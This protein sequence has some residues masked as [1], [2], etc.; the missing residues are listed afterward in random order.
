[1]HLSF[2]CFKWAKLMLSIEQSI[3][4]K[5][6]LKNK[7]KY[8]HVVNANERSFI[9]QWKQSDAER[10]YLKSRKDI[11]REQIKNIHSNQDQYR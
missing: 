5:E 3:S 2:V 1:M 4:V 8:S 10:E 9:V 6:R 11:F 7:E